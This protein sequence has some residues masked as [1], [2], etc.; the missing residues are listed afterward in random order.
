ML[1]TGIDPMLSIFFCWA[2]TR[3]W[4]CLANA[5]R[6][7]GSFSSSF[8]DGDTLEDEAA[9]LAGAR[10][11]LNGKSK[12]IHKH[13]HKHNKSKPKPNQTERIAHFVFN[14]MWIHFGPAWREYIVW[15]WYTHQAQRGLIRR[16]REIRIF[17][18]FSFFMHARIIS[19][20]DFRTIHLKIITPKRAFLGV[21]IGS[22]MS[23]SGDLGPVRM[24]R[25]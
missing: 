12:T 5:L 24:F 17:G 11:A 25:L 1:Q 16:D 7:A 2:A 10:N 19:H 13:K 4:Y 9:E 21:M 6:K 23:F 22:L 20:I 14:F 3:L 8:H 18:N 15:G